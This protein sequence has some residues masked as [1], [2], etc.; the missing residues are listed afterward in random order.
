M[1]K[2]SNYIINHEEMTITMTR[3]FA[4][5]ANIINSDEYRALVQF[6]KDFT[7]YTI[8]TQETKEAR[9]KNTHK[10]LT[11]PV[12][13]KYLETRDNAA[14]ALRAFELAKAYY[15]GQPAYY[16]KVKAWFFSNYKEDYL[17]YAPA[18]TVAETTQSEEDT[19]LENPAPALNV[20]ITPLNN[21]A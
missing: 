20:D 16:A 17:K 6:R 1:T 12:M 15:K 9:N 10:G 19:P 4:K 8:K 5:R 13:K 14:D 3:D 21:A 2:T 18:A 11:L 7:D